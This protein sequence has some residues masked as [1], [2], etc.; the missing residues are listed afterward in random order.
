MCLACGEPTDKKVIRLRDGNK[1]SINF[2][3]YCGLE[4]FNNE[5]LNLIEENKYE[6][7][8][9]GSVGLDI[10]SIEEDFQNG[11]EQSKKYVETYIDKK[12]SGDILEI[13]CSYGYFLK[14]SYDL[15]H[16][17]V[18]V[19]KNPIRRKYVEK[20]LAIKCYPD[21]KT[22]EIEKRKFDKIF[23]F[24]VIEYIDKP[25]EYVKRLI[26]L[27]NNNGEIIIITPN[28][29]DVLKKYWNLR[30]YKNFFYERQSICYFTLNA[31]K[32][33]L[34]NIKGDN[35]SFSIDTKQGYSI[36]NHLSW[37]FTKKP[38]TT[39]IVG[40]DD[41]K[42]T[43]YESLVE[44]KKISKELRNYINKIDLEYKAM[45]ESNNL[46]NQIIIRIKKKI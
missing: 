12:W 38:S 3:K 44:R 35:F 21:L 10:P 45:I 25:K 22:I 27:L 33:L 46:G 40:G 7:A 31:A 19:E 39:G 28:L 8:R 16:N 43:L 1:D 42:K 32:S 41:F 9:L 13:G 2:C 17:S 11:F 6:E 15:G 30:S 36:F 14:Q 20:E 23:M 24:F 37:Y 18:G 26:D 34:E 29:E 4:F 5:N